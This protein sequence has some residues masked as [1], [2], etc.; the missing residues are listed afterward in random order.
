MESQLYTQ[1]VQTQIPDASQQHSVAPPHEVASRGPEEWSKDRMQN[2]VSL[3][4]QSPSLAS[5]TL[6]GLNEFTL[7]DLSGELLTDI[8][9]TRVCYYTVHTWSMLVYIPKIELPNG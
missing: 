8:A 3:P 6:E 1:W 2:V 9:S 7:G 5:Q 4:V